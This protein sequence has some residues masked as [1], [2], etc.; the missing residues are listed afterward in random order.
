M[1]SI[2][3]AKMRSAPGD[4][5]PAVPRR[6]AVVTAMVKP[7]ALPATPITSDSMK[8]SEPAFSAVCM[9]VSVAIDHRQS[10]RPGPQGFCFIEERE[11]ILMI[12]TQLRM[13][14]EEIVAEQRDIEI[15]QLGARAHRH[16]VGRGVLH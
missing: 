8:E 7:G 12:Q 9:P 16:L 11:L 2:G 1:P 15:P 4:N 3:T 5:V 13:A 10:D 14:V 6:T